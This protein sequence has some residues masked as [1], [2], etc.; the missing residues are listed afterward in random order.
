MKANHTRKITKQELQDE[1]LRLN[2]ENC[3]LHQ[4][5]NAIVNAR[6]E[7][8]HRYKETDGGGTYIWT[9]TDLTRGHGGLFMTTFRYKGQSDQL[10]VRYLDDANIASSLATET[11]RAEKEAID[12]ALALRARQF[13]IRTEEAS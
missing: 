13:D 9:V 8:I 6:L 3:R 7:Q 2:H 11:C 4:A 1:H 5:L 10:T 12:K